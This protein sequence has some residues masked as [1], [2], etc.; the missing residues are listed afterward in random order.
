M[1]CVYEQVRL[2][3]AFRDP[4]E[5]QPTWRNAPGLRSLPAGS[6]LPLLGLLEQRC[7]LS[8]V[9]V[10]ASR[11]VRWGGDPVVMLRVPQGSGAPDRVCGSVRLVAAPE[12]EPVEAVRPSGGHEEERTEREPG[13]R[14]QRRAWNGTE[15]RP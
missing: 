15:S 12:P 5:L 11:D 3:G 13:I 1:F 10:A 7:P 8:G 9:K 2:R 6:R 4:A 14:A